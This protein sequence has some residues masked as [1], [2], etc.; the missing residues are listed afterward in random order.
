MPK[1]PTQAICIVTV[2]GVD[3]VG[4]IADLAQAMARANINIMD[5]N[6][7]IM[8]TYFVMTMAIDMARATVSTDAFKKKLDR[9]ARKLELAF[10]TTGALLAMTVG[11]LVEGPCP[12]IEYFPSE[13]APALPPS[14]AF[15]GRGF[16]SGWL[17]LLY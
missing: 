16:M 9:I 12:L 3:K 11:M 8:E 14:I 7:R 1:K 10:A 5:V 4:I 2:T 6:Q 15:C 17:V 13:V